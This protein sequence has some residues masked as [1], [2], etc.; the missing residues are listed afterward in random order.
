MENPF[1]SGVRPRASCALIHRQKLARVCHLCDGLYLQ[2][3]TLVHL[4]AAEV[5]RRLAAEGLLE[6]V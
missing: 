5:A 4:L 6:S 3:S 1:A 2:V